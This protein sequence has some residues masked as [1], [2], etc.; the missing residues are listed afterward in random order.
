MAL[1]Y[2]QARS[3]IQ[4]GDIV[5]IKNKK[6]LVSRVIQ[7]FT[8]SHYSHVGI[9]FWATIG[10][11]QRLFMV[12]AQGGAKR[13]IVNMS[14]YEGEEM[15]IVMPPKRWAD[16]QQVALERLG[17]VEY[18]WLEAYYVGLREFLLRTTKYIKLP[19][20]DLPGEICSEY[21]ARVYGLQNKHVSP[22][23]LF[24]NLQKIGCKLKFSISR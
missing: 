20:L 10:K 7:F 12:E 6:T 22:Q 8:F 13:R 18:G 21:V 1:S 11:E 14:F 9:A 19:Q 24:E 3:K 17:K 23:L 4:D 15:D 2:E 5:F 16:V